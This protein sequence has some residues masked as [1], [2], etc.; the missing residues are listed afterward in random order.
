MN[1][2]FHKLNY[3]NQACL[4]VLNAPESF[5]PE[6]SEMEQ[7]CKL[8]RKHTG[9]K[10][11]EFA[12]LFVTKLAEVEKLCAAI[13]PKLKEDAVLWFAYPKGTSKKYSCDFNRDNGWAAAEALGYIPVRAVAIDADWSA[14]RLRQTKYIKTITRKS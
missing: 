9:L 5:E 6:L 2:T 12:L 3:K 10:E 7:S 14:L 4:L 8:M 13:L 1:Q 11:I